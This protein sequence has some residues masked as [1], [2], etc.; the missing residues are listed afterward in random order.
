[1]QNK[2]DLLEAKN[3][4]NEA[5]IKEQEEEIL[6]LKTKIESDHFPTSFNDE[7]VLH[8]TDN[9]TNRMNKNLVASDDS[10]ARAYIPSSCRELGIAGHSLDGLYLV[11]NVDNNQIQTVF[12]EFGTSGIKLECYK[13]SL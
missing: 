11:Q 12:C 2:V 10:S 6:K 4:V 7:R 9:K 8:S 13:V 1:M 5:K 3:F